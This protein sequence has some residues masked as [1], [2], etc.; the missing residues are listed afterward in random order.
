MLKYLL[1]ALFLFSLPLRADDLDTGI[2]KIS[3][4]LSAAVTKSGSKKIS[5][6][7]F[8]DLDG[9][10][11]EFGRFMAEQLSVSL[12]N[13]SKDFAVMDRANMASILKEHQLT[14]SGLVNP[15]NARKLGQFAGVDAIVLGTIT[16][17][18]ASLSVT[19]KVIST[20]TTQVLGATKAT[21]ARSKDID[22]MLPTAKAAPTCRLT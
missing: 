22:A 10:T 13:S 8:A 19:A 1:P 11:S 5:V 17:F 18:G 2:S 20:E 15:D 16:P 9:R 3:N 4:D 7:D 14:A 6:I 21:I 12:V